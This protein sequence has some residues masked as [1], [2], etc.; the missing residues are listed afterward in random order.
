M[1]VRQKLVAKGPIHILQEA[2]IKD[3][4]RTVFLSCQ[5]YGE[6]VNLVFV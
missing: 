5:L 6:P 4:I 1:C 2:M 3:V